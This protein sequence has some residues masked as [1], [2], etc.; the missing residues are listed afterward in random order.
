MCRL[1]TNELIAYEALVKVGYY[2]SLLIGPYNK[3]NKTWELE[4]VF[5]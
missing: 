4:V 1:A 2:Y 5:Q 3:I